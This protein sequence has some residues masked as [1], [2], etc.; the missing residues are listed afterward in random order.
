MLDV[1][2]DLI[3]QYLSHLFDKKQERLSKRKK[4]FVWRSMSGDVAEKH[5]RKGNWKW[6][7]RWV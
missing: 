1:I 5:D 3:W 2:E 6:Q 7:A 4:V